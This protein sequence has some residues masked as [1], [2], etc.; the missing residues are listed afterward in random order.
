MNLI[1][2]FYIQT[3]VTFINQTREANMKQLWINIANDTNGDY[4]ID[5]DRPKAHSELYD[6]FS[7]HWVKSM[8]SNKTNIGRM[9]LWGEHVLFD[10][11]ED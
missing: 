10:E 9:R 7:E 3:G 5:T 8:Y 1:W 11:W 2:S 6:E 4:I